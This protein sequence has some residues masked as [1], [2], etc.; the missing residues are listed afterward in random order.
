MRPLWIAAVP[1]LATLSA[2]P[3]AA[4]VS[5]RV[6]IDIP[7]GRPGPGTY[8][9]HRQ[10]VVREYDQYRFG[11]WDRYYD[12]WQP[13]TVYYYDGYYYDYPI[14]PYAEAIIVYRFR[15]EMF[16]APRQSE[17]IVWQERF[18]SRDYGR[19]YNYGRDYYRPDPRNVRNDRDYR[20]DRNDQRYQQPRDDRN[21]RD[22]RDDRGG[23][24]TRP[25]QPPQPPQPQRPVQPQH[26]DRN[27]HQAPPQSPAHDAYRSRPRGGH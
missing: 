21:G 25:Q 1:I 8:G 6:H 16:F 18:R 27:T 2:A 12:E 19:N 15:D 13:V 10:L 3:A 22:G 20:N 26:D 24:D 9:A 5:A 14:V 11:A 17:F 23:R 4:Q 7:I